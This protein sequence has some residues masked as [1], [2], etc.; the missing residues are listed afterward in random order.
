MN[1]RIAKKIRQLNRRQFLDWAEMV[2]S[3]PIRDR[4]QFCWMV[5]RRKW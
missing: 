5:I 2:Q 4:L 3:W 1:G